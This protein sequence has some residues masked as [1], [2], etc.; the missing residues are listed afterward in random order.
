MCR[1]NIGLAECV[2][3]CHFADA[4]AGPV[5]QGRDKGKGF[6]VTDRETR[7][8]II[9][10]CLEMNATGVNQGTSG[11]ISVR[12]GDGMLITPSA[13]PY[14]RMQPDDI[15][16][17][18]FDGRVEGTRKPSSEWRFH[19]DI[20]R[21]KPGAGAVVHAHPPACTALAIM[22]KPIPPLHYMV[23]AAGG[24][25]IPVAPYATFGTPELSAHAVA[26]LADRD[27]CLLDHHGMIACGATLEK[28]LWLAGEVEALAGQYLA[29][30]PFG[31]PPLL[32]LEQ[33]AEVQ[34][35]F[36]GYGIED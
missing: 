36:A 19:L 23:A 3:A 18:G 21:A 26:A 17:M 6:D 1:G 24:H 32:S 34:A 16:W 11:N 31:E 8:A 2:I 14:A 20:L 15:V 13:L 12:A 4:G 7:Q 22:G 33:I 10:A 30:L 5:W 27:A 25:D 9:E 29:C 28:A 35:K